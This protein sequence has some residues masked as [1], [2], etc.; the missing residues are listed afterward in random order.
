MGVLRY[1]PGSE[2][3]EQ[4]ASSEPDRSGSD[5]AAWAVPVLGPGEVEQPRSEPAPADRRA[6]RRA[7]SVALAALTRH[8]ASEAELRAKLL[9]RG[10]DEAATE[11]E[12]DRLKSAGLIDDAALADRLVRSLRER[13]GLGDGALR[14]ALRARHL[15]AAVI[16]A[17]LAANA[18]DEEVVG[19]RLQDVA[20]D[21]ARRLVSF[22]A[23][24]AERRLTAYLLRRGYAGSSVRSAVR[25]A[26]ERARDG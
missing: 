26:L 19:E 23:D 6:E 25:E 3:P 22:P 5:E 20:D 14:P 10:L 17:A 2:P 11:A 4:R 18:E 8:D 21:R 7:E 15:P 12:L 1:F 16:E 13:K 9:A 24:V